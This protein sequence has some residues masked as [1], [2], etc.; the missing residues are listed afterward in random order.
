MSCWAS[1][2]ANDTIQ[3]FAFSQLNRPALYFQELLTT[4]VRI[5]AGR[6]RGQALEDF[7]E[8]A[9]QLLRKGEERMRKRG[10]SDKETTD[11]VAFAVV[12]FLDESVLS[13]AIGA[14]RGYATNPIGAQKYGAHVAGE[15]FFEKLD[16]LL[17]A[18]DSTRV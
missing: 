4:T 17:H 7:R 13:S 12:A 16:I 8:D 18:Q 3:E 15:V 2:M 10:Y 14:F 6:G 9:I 11:F 1:K 5:R